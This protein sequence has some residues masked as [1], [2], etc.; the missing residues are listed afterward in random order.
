MKLENNLRQAINIFKSRKFKSF[1][2]WA[3]SSRKFKIGAS[4]LLLFLIGLLWASRSHSPEMDLKNAQYCLV[5]RG[6]M[7][8]SILQAGELEAKRSVDIINEAKHKAE[9]V[10]IV[11]DGA[12][13]TNGQLLVQLSSSDLQ[14]ESLRQQ[15]DVASAEASLKNAQEQISIAEIRYK[16][17]LASSELEVEQAEMELRKYQEAEYPQSVLRAQSNIKLAEQELKRARTTLEGTKMLHEKGYATGEQLEADELGV[18]RKSIEVENRKKDLVILTNYNHA[19]VLKQK[20]NN[21]SKAKAN[22]MKLKRTHSSQKMQN[23]ADLISYKTRLEIKRNSFQKTKQELENANIYATFSGQ[24]FYPQSRRSQNEIEKG[25]SVRYRQKI[26]EFPDMSSWNITVGVPESII[27][28]IEKGQKAVA[29]LEAIPGEFLQA[30]VIKISAVPD[31]QRWFSSNA[32]TY[33]VTLE[34]TNLPDA[35]LKPGMS[36]VVEIITR[37]LEDV[38]YIPIQALVSDEDRHFVYLLKGNS[39]EKTEVEV[40]R[41]NENYIQIMNENLVGQQLLLYAPV[42]MEIKSG[43][44]ERPLKKMKQSDQ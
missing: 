1:L 21:L 23:E 19:Q 34:V 3:R 14:D 7:T 22:L 26:L 16:T 5:E 37:E 32:K 43:L 12:V 30:K 27:D 11:E 8:I 42:E 24:V 6:N 44:Q 10:E 39:V 36:A 15:A 31:R 25:A 2:L 28:R 29:T 35:K 33:T 41:D 4:V 18:E 40:G 9:I 13:V 17:D 38:V 20:E